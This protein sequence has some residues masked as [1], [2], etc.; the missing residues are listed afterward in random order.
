MY[1]TGP[2]C[3]SN[4][5]VLVWLIYLPTRIFAAGLSTPIDFRIVAPSLVT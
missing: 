3:T 4:G 2:A 5:Q 1:I